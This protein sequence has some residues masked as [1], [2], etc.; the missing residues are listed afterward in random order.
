MKKQ[1]I[2]ESVDTDNISGSDLQKIAEIEKD[3]W[4]HWLWEY[5]ECQNCW[6]I[7]SK[8][9]IFWNLSKDIYLKTVSEIESI[10]LLDSIRCTNCW[11][12][13]EYI[14]DENKYIEKIRDRYKNS[15][16]AFLVVFRDEY[17]EIKWFTDWY[18]DG[19]D[20]IYKR[21]FEKYYSL[22]W[23]DKILD[24]INEN[25]WFIPDN[26]LL[27]SA[28]WLHWKNTGDFVLNYLMHMFYLEVS[29]YNIW[30]IWLFEASLWSKMQK[31]Y[32]NLWCRE[33]WFSDY[34][35]NIHEGNRSDI[36]VHSNIVEAFLG[37]EIY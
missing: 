23:K 35:G 20:N 27:C 25:I 5:V 16:K 36:F 12:Y 29:K 9:D 24:K 32:S 22:V 18:I 10:L 8:K 33:L 30:V 7:S 13:T 37:K 28:I 14:Y 6:M 21:E 19:F 3:M 2:I 15:I 17:W 11:E 26:F 34:V 1:L 4:S 31:Y